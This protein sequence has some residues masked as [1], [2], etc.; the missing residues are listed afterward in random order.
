MPPGYHIDWAG[1]YESQQRAQRRLAIIIPLTLLVIFMIL[2][3]MFGSMKWALLIF[4]NVAV[5][6]I[7]GVLALYPDRH[8]LQ[9]VF[10]RWIPGAVRRFRADRRHHG[11]VHQPTARPRAHGFRRREGRRHPA[12]CVPS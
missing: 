11:G 6:P 5:A 12:A 7:G 8:Q 3:S 9:R 4:A 10:R 1:E 2:Y